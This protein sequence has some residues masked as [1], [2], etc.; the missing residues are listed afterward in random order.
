MSLQNMAKM[1]KAL[2]EYNSI[3]VCDL[4]TSLGSNRRTWGYFGAQKDE[5]YDNYARFPLNEKG[6]QISD[7]PLVYEHGKSYY[8]IRDSKVV[9]E[10]YGWLARYPYIGDRLHK[11]PD[12]YRRIGEVIA[13]AIITS[14]GN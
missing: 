3:P 14:Y 4:F 9:S 11:S 12:G 6:E 1:Q 2:G 10:V 5:Y 8:Q 7:E 13:G